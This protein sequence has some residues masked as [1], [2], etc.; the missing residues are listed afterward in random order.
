VL[1]QEDM[2]LV[3]LGLLPAQRADLQLST[4]D[5]GQLATGLGGFLTANLT[6]ANRA[7]WPA[8]NVTLRVTLHPRLALQETQPS[9]MADNGMVVLRLGDLA[10]GGVANATLTFTALASGP[11]PL[12]AV[13]ASASGEANPADNRLVVPF[14][15]WPPSRV[16]IT[17]QAVAEGNG[18]TSLPRLTARLSGPRDAA[19]RIPF[20]VEPVTATADDLFSGATGEL[21]FPLYSDVASAE[22][23]VRGDLVFE[24][25]EAIRVVL[26]PP[27]TVTAST[28][29]VLVTLLNDDWPTLS[30][31]G[32][33]VREGQAGLTNVALRVTLQP[34]AAVPVTADYEI[35]GLTAAEGTDFTG[36]A[37]R[38]RFLPG[39]SE[40]TVNVGVLFDTEPEADE[41]FGLWLADAPLAATAG[42]FA[43]GTILN[44]DG[45]PVPTLTTIT[46]AGGAVGLEWTAL[47][48]LRYDVERRGA[49][50][51]NRWQQVGRITA[52]GVRA[53]WNDP[54]PPSGEGYYRIRVAP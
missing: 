25:D 8:S 10:P 17:D 41:T 19:V 11:A 42:A 3:R 9:A 26:H 2:A 37:G 51:T 22:L 4:L 23:P 49:F 33:S 15:V 31:T 34:A 14:T 20:T 40:L 5:N 52:A 7:I 46:L 54:S 47:A 18:S 6:V 27:A 12:N 44:D 48:G 28:T 30:V 53:F 1:G 38:V 45:V 24:P 16:F 21:V 50:D 13:A 32:R 43:L 29:N 39:Q 36:F 35:A